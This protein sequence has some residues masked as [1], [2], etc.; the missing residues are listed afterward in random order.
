MSDFEKAVAFVLDHEVV[1]KKGHYG[2]WNF[3]VSENVTG[4]KGGLTKYGIDKRSHG[5]VDIENLTLEQA[6]EIYR[7]EYWLKGKCDQMPWPVS[8]AH[9]DACVNTGLGQ[10]AKFLQRVIGVDSDGAI[11]P[12]TLKALIIAA[13]TRGPVAIAEDIVSSREKFYKQ[14]AAENQDDEE[15]LD[16]WLNRVSDLK[17]TISYA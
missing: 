15:F 9:F 12:K 11:G 5:D 13:G 2:D 3:V 14:L 1:F 10:A 16:G 8:L 4:D 7:V 17:K 6:K